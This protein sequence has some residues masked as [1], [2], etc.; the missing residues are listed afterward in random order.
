MFLFSLRTVR[1]ILVLRR[2]DGMVMLISVV[3]GWD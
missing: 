3:R 2:Q 1:C